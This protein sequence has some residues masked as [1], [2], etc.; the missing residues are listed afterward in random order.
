MSRT[1]WQRVALIT[2]VIPESSKP[3]A[4]VHKHPRWRD[5]RST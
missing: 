1:T 4:E 5:A 2:Y 3:F